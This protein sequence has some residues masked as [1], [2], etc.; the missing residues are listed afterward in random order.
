MGLKR[1]AEA[2]SA[3]TA[4]LAGQGRPVWKAAAL[5]KRGC[6]KDILGRRQDAIQDY[7]AMAKTND[8]WLEADRASIYLGRPF[9]WADFP[10]EISPRGF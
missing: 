3:F 6:A 9:T 8:P 2:E 10:R 5:L 4:S 7:R 1:P